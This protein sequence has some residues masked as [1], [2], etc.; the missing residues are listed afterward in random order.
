MS[1]KSTEQVLREALSRLVRMDLV[2]SYDLLSQS[3]Q[4][5]K[6]VA[7]QALA[8]PETVNPIRIIEGMRQER[9]DHAERAQ[10][11]TSRTLCLVKIDVLDRVLN[12]LAQPEHVEMVTFSSSDAVIET[13]YEDAPQPP[14]VEI[15]SGP[16]QPDPLAQV[17]RLLDEEIAEC[18]QR[19]KALRRQIKAEMAAEMPI[20]S[21]AASAVSLTH[22]LEARA[23]Y[24]QVK[25]R[26]AALQEEKTP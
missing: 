26:I 19:A 2:D 14:F 18:E 7:R 15:A 17:Q 21:A 1:E 13:D 8:L 12:A 25:L 4:D 24:R 6:H 9:L 20:G 11:A 22:Y 5:A 3:Y 23:I 16:P 10:D